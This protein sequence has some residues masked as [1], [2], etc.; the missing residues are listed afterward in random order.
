MASDMNKLDDLPT[1]DR[2]PED[3]VKGEGLVQEHFLRH[4]LP[5]LKSASAYEL[6]EN[7]C[8]RFGVSDEK[9]RRMHIVRENRNKIL[10]KKDS[11]TCF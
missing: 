11:I 8:K 10:A 6:V 5:D 7:F 2:Y 9:K 3:V 4:P 1:W